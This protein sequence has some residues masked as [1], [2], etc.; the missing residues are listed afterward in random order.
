MFQMSY[1]NKKSRI[2]FCQNKK[3]LFVWK[4]RNKLSRDACIL[5]LIISKG[6]ETNLIPGTEIYSTSSH[7]CETN[8][9][10][11]LQSRKLP[12]P[13]TVLP[14]RRYSCD[15]FAYVY[16]HWIVYVARHIP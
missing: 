7:M 1:S 12:A 16:E 14:G 3:I 15:M 6:Y 9:N 8:L 10:P 11:R 5:S 2:F 4:T 13:N